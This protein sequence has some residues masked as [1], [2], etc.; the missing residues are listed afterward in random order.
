MSELQ[1]RSG[2][3][4]GPGML[5]G[6]FADGAAGEAPAESTE[7]VFYA[8]TQKFVER[9]EDIPEDAK[10][11]L[12][13]T[14]AVGHHTGVVDCFEPRLACPVRVLDAV[15][16]DLPEDGAAAAKLGALRRFGEIQID[17]ESAPA[18]YDAAC[19]LREAL[20][21]RGSRKAGLDVMDPDFGIH[22]QEVAFLSSFI[23][24]VGDVLK[25]GGFYVTGRLS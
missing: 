13:Y 2:Y 19:A 7:A 10:D 1:D 5:G 24:L 4:A 16:A 6:S 12:T 15:V 21:Y 11:V 9:E 22:A 14:L 8:L 20:G 23:E 17:K 25:V 18:L 3:F